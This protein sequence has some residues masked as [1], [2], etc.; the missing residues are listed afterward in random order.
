METVIKIGLDKGFEQAYKEN[1]DQYGEDLR[2][3]NGF[4][5]AQ[6]GYTE[7]IDNFV[8]KTTV[9]DAQ[10]DGNSNVGHKDIVTLQNE[11]AKPHSK[12]L[13]F[14]KIFYEINKKYGEEV[15]KQWLRA[16]WDGHFY[17]HDA[18]NSTFVPYCFAY[19]I[20]KLVNEGLYFIS[21]FN[22]QPPQ[23]LTTFTDFVGEFVSWNCNRSS[24]AVGLPSFLIYSYYFWRKDVENNY[25]LGSPE[26]YRDQCF[27][28]IV[29]RLNQ[30]FLRGG[31]QSAFTNFSIFDRPYFEALFGGKTFPDGSY[32]ID[33][34]EEFMDYQKAF[35]KIVS[36]IRSENMMTFPVLTFSLLRQNGKFVDEEFAKWAC[37]HNMTWADSNFYISEDV[38][39]LSNCCFDGSQKTLTKSSDG[40]NCM[41][42]E[43]LYNAPYNENKRNFTIFHNGNWVKGKVIRLPS[44]DMY[45]VLTAN[46]KEFIMTDNHISVTLNGNKETKDLSTN[47]YLMFNSK[48]LNAPHETDKKLTYEQG[49][50][51]GMYLG[52]GNMQKEE[53]SFTTTVNLS[54]NKHKF[55]KSK[56]ILRKAVS[57]FSKSGT[58]V[59]LGSEYNNVYPV[60]IRDNDVA[61]FIREFVSGKYSFEKSLN[62]NCILQS[63]DFRRGI[64]DG[65]YLTDG[66]NSNRIYSSSKELIDNIECLCTS[67]GMNT[68]VDVS[69]RTGE[70]RVEIRGENFNRNYPIYCIRW[71]ETYK[72]KQKDVYRWKNN[73]IYF[74]IKSIEKYESDSSYCYCFQ[75]E[76]EDEP[77][78]T[79][80]NGL[81]THNCRLVSNV[82]NLGYFNSL[83]GTALE[84]GSLK[85]NTVNLARLAYEN[86]TAKEYFES[87]RYYVL[88]CLKCLDRVRYIIKRN[89]DKGLLPNYS[90]GTINMKS[91]Y[92]SLGVLG[93]FEAIEHYGMTVTDEFGNTFYTDEGIEF[94]KQLFKVV[95]ETIEEFKQSEN[96]DY[97]INI[98]QIPGERA[99]AVLMEKDRIFFPNEKYTLPLYGNQFIPL[100]VKTTLQEK[101]RLSAIFDKAC[102]GGSISH[103]NIDAPFN[104]FET[105]WNLLNYIADQGVVYFA[106][107]LRISA[108]KHNHG[109]YGET[110]PICGEPVETTYQRIVGFLT[111]EKTYSK[112]RKAEFVKRT[113]LDL[114]EMKELG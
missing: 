82:Q 41:T 60:T 114:N 58:I 32:M 93:M 55:E 56:E 59:K 17:L 5:D 68:I 64:L 48:I 6:L 101:I 34:E 80:P 65:Y 12:L 11:M 26:K 75:M 105:A 84:V 111:P 43:E 81:I 22:A 95:H 99:A 27:Q 98:E 83:G 78:F 87:L 8:D 69:D 24:G 109:F 100:G 37:K 14:N 106:F 20:D 54:L 71:Y 90:V 30:P 89:V 63:V 4:G 1:C 42:F 108:C 96:V 44:R 35:M 104:S 47:D 15:A 61:L 16:E 62:M 23:H 38:T 3:L 88:L 33:D 39:S 36:Q 94:G 46:N 49:F 113:W 51:I 70:G 76:D 102:N 10:I 112:P 25:Y 9:A 107:N 72:R 110:C 57:Q 18:Y 97:M 29:Y 85:V 28:E 52:D 50:L 66:G 74:K 53:A 45:K 13:A 92:N 31:I 19:D 2:A 67:L 79:L 40:V 91:Q 103:I 86:N 73:S 7:F 77:Y 21:G